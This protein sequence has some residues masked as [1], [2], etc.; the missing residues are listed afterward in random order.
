MVEIQEVGDQ[1]NEQIQVIG[2]GWGKTGTNNVKEALNQLGYKCYH[3]SEV[4][5]NPEHIDMWFEALE[6]KETYDWDKI[7]KGYNAA[8]DWPTAYFYK[9]RALL[10]VTQ[11]TKLLNLLNLKKLITFFRNLSPNILMPR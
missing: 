7:Y 1:N 2:V 9:V 3:M 5:E 6:K 8:V 4:F 10:Y 11:I